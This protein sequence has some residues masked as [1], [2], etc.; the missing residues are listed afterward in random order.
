MNRAS[1]SASPRCPRHT[2]PFTVSFLDSSE[3]FGS[4]EHTDPKLLRKLRQ[5]QLQQKFRK[6]MEARKLQQEQGQTKSE[7]TELP[8]GRGGSGG[9]ASATFCELLLLFLITLRRLKV[10]N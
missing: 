7:D 6:E 8:I 1:F 3:A 10:V 2:L 4:G 5:Q 9:S